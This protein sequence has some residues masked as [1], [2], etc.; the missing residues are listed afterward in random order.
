[1]A[2]YGGKGTNRKKPMHK[3]ETVAKALI[4]NRGMVT[5]AARELKL[6]VSGVY[7]YIKRYAKCRQAL[8]DAR[9]VEL[10]NAE[11]QLFQ[12]IEDG[13][14]NA[15]RFYLSTIGKERGY[16]ERTEHTGARD[17]QPDFV[18]TLDIPG[19]N[20]VGKSNG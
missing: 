10:D 3:A 2:N 17:G 11:S 5:R 7:L 12:M 6:S 19:N 9:A 20:D 14:Y 13:D 15:V 8:E 18:F 4:R 1:M 16:T